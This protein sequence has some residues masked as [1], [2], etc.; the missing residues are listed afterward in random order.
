MQGTEAIQR[1]D[2]WLIG[3]YIANYALAVLAIAGF[4]Y[5]AWSG[6][7]TSEA[8]KVASEAL[9][10]AKE[11]FVATTEPLVK[12]MEIYLQSTNAKPPSCENPPTELRTMLYNVSQVAVQVK[13]EEQEIY[14]GERKLNDPEIVEKSKEPFIL[15]PGE[16]IGI[17]AMYAEIGNLYTTP[18]PVNYGPRLSMKLSVTFSKI[19]DSKQYLYKVHKEAL[20]SCTTPDQTAY[21]TRSESIEVI[22]N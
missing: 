7:K 15:A 3:Y 10:Q 9:H 16:H 14:I 5:S 21:T 4:S 19:G 8:L 18:K 22:N 2:S 20:Y 17:S 1:P 11:S 13:T 6:R 12:V